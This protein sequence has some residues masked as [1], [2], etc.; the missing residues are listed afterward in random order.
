MVAGT[1]L[2][3]NASVFT[4]QYHTID[5]N[6]NLIRKASTRNRVTFEHNNALSGN[7]ER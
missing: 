3:P 4:S 7:E 5:V 1:D 6:K 2:S